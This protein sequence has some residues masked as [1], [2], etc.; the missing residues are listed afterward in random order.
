MKRSNAD[1]ELAD[2]IL[3]AFRASRLSIKQLAVESGV[4]YASAHGFLSGGCDV[5]LGT[6]AKL[7]KVLGLQL[8]TPTA[9]CLIDPLH[10]GRLTGKLPA[11]WSR[12][13]WLIRTPDGG[14]L[15]LFVVELRQII[16]QSARSLSDALQPLGAGLRD[17]QFTG[18]LMRVEQLRNPP[19]APPEQQSPENRTGDIDDAGVADVGDSD[20]REAEAIQSVEA[21][22]EAGPVL[23][24]GWM[25]GEA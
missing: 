12:K 17:V 9:A 1:N 7:C 8:T 22:A 18:C 2:V 10:T 16:P 15:G 3:T 25:D 11:G 13:D 5:A 21:K 19:S 20:A 14:E 23:R 24:R 6:A 4:P